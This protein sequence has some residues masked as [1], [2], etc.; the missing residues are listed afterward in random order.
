MMYSLETACQI[1]I[2]ALAGGA[3]VIPIGDD[4]LAG[5]EHALDVQRQA[6]G[7]ALWPAVLRKLDRRNPGYDQ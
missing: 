1:Q 7:D 4:V 5:V 2:G 6:I 3:E